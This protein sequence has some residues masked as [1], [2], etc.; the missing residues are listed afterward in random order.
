[1]RWT[2]YLFAALILTGVLGTTYVYRHFQASE[3]EASVLE[4]RATIVLSDADKKLIE[5]RDS[6]SKWLL[7]LAMALLPGLVVKKSAEGETTVQDE[8]LPLLAGATL[9]ISL[10][11]FFLA[12]D[13]VA[14]V[15]SRGPQYHLYGW[16]SNFPIL[17]QFWSLLIALVMLMSHWL[18]PRTKVMFP[19]LAIFLAMLAPSDDVYAVSFSTNSA[20][21]CVVAW[22]KSR[23]VTFSDDEVGLAA[24]VTASLARRS[25]VSPIDVCEFVRVQ[26]DQ[27]RFSASQASARSKQPS[28]VDALRD[29]N[30]DLKNTAISS[31]T[32][33]E[34]LLS[35][36]ALWRTPSG[37]LH[38]EGT[39][40]GATVIINSRPVGFTNLDL[41]LAPGKYFVEVVADGEVIFRKA[42]VLIEDG[43]LWKSTFVK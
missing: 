30:D 19:T 25:N 11:S 39:P 28:I 23:E 42:D 29:T 40:K 22:A 2:F 6:T 18:K 41:R 35:L 20:K 24:R 10:Y 8:L 3:S 36:G 26:L 21:P 32:A 33:L 16:V 37:L 38:L 34:R 1:M 5:V 27:V 13:S 31:G 43:K 9:V 4:N 12:Q 14:F 7:G 17:L 15:L